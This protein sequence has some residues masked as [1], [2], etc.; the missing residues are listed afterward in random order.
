MI[1]VDVQIPFEVKPARKKP[2]KTSPTQ[3]S[4]AHLRK[5]GYLCA[6]VEKWNM[7]AKIRQDMFGIIDLV[8]IKDD[9]IIGI[10]A[11]SGD[12]V[13]ARITKISEHENYPI[14]IKAMRIIVHGW[15]K[16]SMGKWI[17]RE[18]EL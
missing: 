11:T 14:V 9:D 2:A 17:L 18:V 13:S 16:N 8:A 5:N 1:A 15:R 7:H 10:Q 4:L 6:I 3:R 12:N